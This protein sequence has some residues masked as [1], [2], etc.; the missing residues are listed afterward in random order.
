V[1]LGFLAIKMPAGVTRDFSGLDLAGDLGYL[2]AKFS[3]KGLLG[4]LF[5]AS[6]GQGGFNSS[7]LS[8]DGGQRL[9]LG[10]F[11]RA[12]P[13]RVG[14]EVEFLNLDEPGEERHGAGSWPR[15]YHRIVH[16]GCNP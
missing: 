14:S 7:D 3:L 1:S 5:G 15:G 6:R 9:T 8:L 11:L 12:P 16:P 13:S 10:T 4:C 2:L